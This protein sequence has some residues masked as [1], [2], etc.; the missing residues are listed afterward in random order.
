M[1]GITT[2]GYG[3]GDKIIISSFPENYYR[4]TGEKVIDIHKNWVFQ[5]NPY[6]IRDEV[7]SKIINFWNLDDIKYNLLK[8]CTIPSVSE[9]ICKNFNFETYLR[10]PRLYIHEDLPI[11]NNQVC[12][13]LNGVSVGN[14]PDFIVEQIINNY[15]GFDIVQIGSKT[16]YFGN[17]IK[18]YNGI[19]DKLGLDIWDS[20]KIIAESIIFIGVDSGMMNA[21]FCYPRVN[22]RIIVLYEP[23]YIKKTFPMESTNI[24]SQWLDHSFTYFNKFDRDIGFTFSYKKI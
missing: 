2:S 11:K 1:I 23:E 18:T 14:C 17:P 12:V 13:H 22:K 21:A 20:I 4:N 19:I 9:N 5:Y 15:K 16:D 8:S 7:P 3:I 24:Y 10:H 6:I